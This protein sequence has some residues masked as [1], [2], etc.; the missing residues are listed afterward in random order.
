M[1]V[2]LCYFVAESVLVLLL[3]EIPAL[4]DHYCF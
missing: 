1:V 4:V 3:V 2:R